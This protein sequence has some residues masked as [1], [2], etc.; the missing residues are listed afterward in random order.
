MKLWELLALVPIILTFVLGA[1]VASGQTRTAAVDSTPITQT[2]S[3]YPFL[4][5]SLL[6]VFVCS[7]IFFLAREVRREEREKRKSD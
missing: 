5:V 1:N 2:G 7:A 4:A 6:L 3:I